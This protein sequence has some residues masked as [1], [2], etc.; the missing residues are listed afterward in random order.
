MSRVA[1]GAVISS[2]SSS[3]LSIST[4]PSNHNGATVGI[5]TPVIRGG[6]GAEPAVKY[7]KRLRNA[8]STESLNTK[9]RPLTQ[10]SGKYVV[11]DTFIFNYNLPEQLS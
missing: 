9:G 11:V 5:V 8:V 1:G 4:V 10:G 2:N 7:S 6:G 3:N